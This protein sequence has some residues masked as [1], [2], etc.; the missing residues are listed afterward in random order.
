ML[1]SKR[2]WIKFTF[3]KLLLDNATKII[4]QNETKI[5]Q[6]CKKYGV[7]KLF[8]FDFS[9]KLI[10]EFKSACTIFLMMSLRQ[11]LRR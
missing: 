8:I 6:L 11:R 10:G 9:T 2:E 4:L 7:E 1:K 3:K 5:H